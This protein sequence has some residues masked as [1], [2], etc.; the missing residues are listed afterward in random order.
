LPNGSEIRGAA[1]F[2]VDG[3]KTVE[4]N[5]S[6]G[7]RS[8]AHGIRICFHGPNE[9]SIQNI[10]PIVPAMEPAAHMSGEALATEVRWAENCRLGHVGN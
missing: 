7:K 2:P 3:K 8:K 6:H 1:H 4:N 9:V 5:F 10:Q